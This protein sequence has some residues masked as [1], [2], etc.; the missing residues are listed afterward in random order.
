MSDQNFIKRI[1]PMLILNVLKAHSDEDN[2]LQV[3]EVVRFLEEDYGITMERKAVSR[4]LNDLYEISEIPYNPT[5]WRIPVHF[6]IKC[7]SRHRS[8]GDIRSN[9]RI[10]SVLEDAEVRLLTDALLAVRNYTSEN[11]LIKL[12]ELGSKTLKENSQYIRVLSNKKIGN[13]QLMIN[14]DVLIRAIIRGKKVSFQYCDHGSDKRLYPQLNQDGQ[15]RTFVASPYQM[16]FRDGYYYLICGC[17]DSQDVVNYRIGRIR[18]LKILEEPVRAYGQVSGEKNRQ[19]NLRKYV[20]EHIHMYSGPSVTAS[21]RIP[22]EMIGDVIDTFGENVDMTRAGD[23]ESI[24]RADV[25][26]AAMIRFAKTFAPTVRVISPADLVEDVKRA[27][28]EALKGYEQ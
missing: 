14:I 3:N 23:S 21:F 25:N 4:T 27:L 12:Q 15:P 6:S 8:T 1:A 11:L 9:W 2:G 18:E 10:G 17:E 24:V 19:F 13:S 7:D 28:L 16:V 22:N 20:D 5:N 26:R